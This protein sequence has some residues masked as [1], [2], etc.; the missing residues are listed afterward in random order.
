MSTTGRPEES[1]PAASEVASRLR[2]ADFVRLVA[3]ATGDGVAA[4][5]L[6]TTALEARGVAHQSSVVPLPEPADRATDAD[7]TIALGRPAVDAELALGA[8]RQPASVT[9]LSVA[10][11]LGTADYELALAG[12]VADGAT[13]ASDVLAAAAERGIERRPGVAAPSPNLADALAHSALV[14]APFSGDIE[15]A[16]EAL[17][18]IGASDPAEDEETRRA[19]ASLVAFEVCAAEASTPHAAD[20]VER[21][22]R[23]LAAPGGRF[24]T[25]E[26]YADVLDATARE[27]PGLAVALALGGVG[28]ADGL[29]IW[30]AHSRRAHEAV[31]SASTGRYDGL[32]VVQCDGDQPLGTVGRIVAD[33]RSPEP[34]VLAVDDSGAVAVPGG[35]FTGHLGSHVAE[36]ATAVGGVGEGTATVGHAHHDGDPTEFVVAFREVTA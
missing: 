36:A 27:Q 32:Y 30:R 3:A 29:D 24:E 10:T 35:E 26:G 28:P 21:F 1:A 18:G 25:V 20:A 13:P 23:P 12:I 8:D 6:L 16:E 5:T 31:R 14:S 15:A 7:L 22:L 4:M 33:Y 9:A 2:E 19:V 11:E 17:A 34:L